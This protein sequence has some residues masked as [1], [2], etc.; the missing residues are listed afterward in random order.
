MKGHWP[1]YVTEA[2]GLGVFMISAS[3]FGVLLF[4]PASPAATAVTTGI[5]RNALMG[6]AMALTAVGLIYNRW[7]QQSGAHFNPAVTLTFYMLGKVAPRDVLAYSVAQFVGGAFGMFLATQALRPWIGHPA[8][9][10]VE[11][12]PGPWG[13]GA[14]WLAEFA[15]T[16][17]LMTVVLTVSNTR[18]FARYTGVCAAACVFLFI[19][20]EAPLSGMSLNPARSLASALA[21]GDGTSLWVYFT[22]PPLGMLAAASVFVRLRGRQ[23]VA[24][25]KLHHWNSRRCIFC[26]FQAM[27]RA[28]VATKICQPALI[29]GK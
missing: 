21:A 25:A 1:E 5:T 9:S 24:C 8:V 6:L 3:V 19:T 13:E 7:G 17:V 23:A 11:T 20:F 16:F 4:H 18:R 10:F 2:A 27:E 26:E 14:A 12:R 29:T 15:L 22:A 28:A